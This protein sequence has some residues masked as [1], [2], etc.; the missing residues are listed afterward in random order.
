MLLSSIQFPFLPFYVKAIPLQALERPLGF[1]EVGAP[2]TSRHSPLEGGKVDS[3]TYQ[4]SLPPGM[5]PGA[6]FC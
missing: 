5:I 3:P 6:H 1:Q 2:R 4:P